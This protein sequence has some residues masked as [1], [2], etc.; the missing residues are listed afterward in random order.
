MVITVAR[1]KWAIGLL[2]PVLFVGAVQF[3]SAQSANPIAVV[4]GDNHSCALDSAGKAWCWGSNAHGGLGNGN[5][6]NQNLPQ[7]VLDLDEIT[8]LT[9]GRNHTCALVQNATV[10]CWGAITS[11][12]LETGPGPTQPIRFWFPE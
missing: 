9:A 2:A 8:Q 3:A 5:R 12:S 4:A 1:P 7:A 6:I 11:V 10:Y